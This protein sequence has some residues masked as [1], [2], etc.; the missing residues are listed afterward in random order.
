M[1]IRWSAPFQAPPSIEA[2]SNSSFLSGRFNLQD[3]QAT[4][5]LEDKKRRLVRKLLREFP[6]VSSYSTVLKLLANGEAEARKQLIKWRDAG[7]FAPR[8]G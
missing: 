3:D 8:K 6:G 5:M 7:T 4:R 2:S 1:G